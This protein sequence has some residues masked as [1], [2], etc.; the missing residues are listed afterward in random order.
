MTMTNTD[1][2]ELTERALRRVKT[3]TKD[4]IVGRIGISVQNGYY[5]SAQVI[6]TTQRDELLEETNSEEEDIVANVYDFVDEQGSVS[7]QRTKKTL[8]MTMSIA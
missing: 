1:I 8:K 5:A 4:N 3:P 7:T 2:I 6:V